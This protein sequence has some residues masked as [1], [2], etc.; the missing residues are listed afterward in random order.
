MPEQPE[1][2]FAS[3]FP[4]LIKVLLTSPGAEIELALYVL[5]VTVLTV[6]KLEIKM[7]EKK[8]VL[9]LKIIFYS[10]ELLDSV[11]SKNKNKF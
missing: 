1:A 7:V 11:S 6:I 5:N 2:L 4:K 9:I 10:L 3:Q 8:N